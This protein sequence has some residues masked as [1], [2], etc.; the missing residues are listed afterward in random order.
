MPKQLSRQPLLFVR[1]RENT[2]DYS[3]KISDGNSNSKYYFHSD[4]ELVKIKKTFIANG[5]YFIEIEFNSITF[6]MRPTHC[7]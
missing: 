3:C 7:I 6:T 1:F 4:Y 2:M 5:M